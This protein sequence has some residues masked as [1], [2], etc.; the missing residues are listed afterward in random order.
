MV[1]KTTEFFPHCYML[2]L[3]SNIHLLSIKLAMEYSTNDFH[4]S[5][6]RSIYFFI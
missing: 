3:Q 1:I 5:Y 6:V 4:Y 2:G